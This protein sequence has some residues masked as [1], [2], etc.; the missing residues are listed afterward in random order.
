[1]ANEEPVEV[2]QRTTLVDVIGVTPL[3]WGKSF[4]AAIGIFA[5]LVRLGK[6]M[7]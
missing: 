2:T 4:L 1:M 6:W 7:G 5:L 3:D